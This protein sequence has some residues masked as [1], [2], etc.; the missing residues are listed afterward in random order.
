LPKSTSLKPGF[1]MIAVG[2]SKS[3]KNVQVSFQTK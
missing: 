3:E 1:D 2:L